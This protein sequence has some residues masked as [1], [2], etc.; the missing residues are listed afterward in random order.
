MPAHRYSSR[1]VV[2]LIAATAIAV[3]ISIATPGARADSATSITA[4]EDHSCAVN[5]AGSAFCWGYSGFGQTGL[6]TSTGPDICGGGLSDEYPCSRTARQVIGLGDDIEA[7][8]AGDNFTCALT[9]SGAVYCW[10]LNEDGRLGA[11]LLSGPQSCEGIFGP[12]P[13]STSPVAV[14]GAGTAAIGAAGFLGGVEEIAVGSSHACALTDAGQV[15]C[16]GWNGFGALG[17]GGFTG[18]EDCD[19]TGCSSV[20][21]EVEGI[22]G[23]VLGITAGGSH[24]CVL[25]EGGSV[26]CWGLNSNG[27]LGIGTSTGPDVC[28]SSRQCSTEPVEVVGLSNAT[29]I[30]A[31][32]SHTCALTEDKDVK[33]WGFNNYGQLGTGSTTGPEGCGAFSDACSDNPVLVTG[34]TDVHELGSASGDTQCAILEDE[35]IKCWGANNLSQLG[36]GN[37]SGPETCE[38]GF[39]CSSTPVLVQTI[40][41]VIAVA[42][43]GDHTCTIREDGEVRCWGSKFWGAT[44]DDTYSSTSAYA[45]TPV[46][47]IGFSGGTPT[48][49]PQTLVWGDLNC[50]GSA[51]P[52]DALAGLRFD[53]GLSVNQAPECPGLDEGVTIGDLLVTWADVDCGGSFSPVDSLKLLRKD[54]GLSVDKAPDC[55]DIGDEVVI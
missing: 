34:L 52:I 15:L 47:V 27:E 17:T 18:P 44:G 13:C 42:N 54:A 3:L 45:H 6:A 35:N 28:F 19:G 25:I 5:L 14:E 22:G 11:G 32:N 20:P 36:I 33:C 53:A 9:Q 37:N 39:K 31:G 24:T 2:L 26:E 10:G 4:G 43:G 7:V 50:N 48:P 21:V 16:W 12:D 29:Q 46:Q 55:P 30:E 8:D 38:S 23:T 49:V 51:D 1:L 40:E 41:D